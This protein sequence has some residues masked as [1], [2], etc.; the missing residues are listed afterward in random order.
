MTVT[1]SASASQE[2]QLTTTTK[3]KKK[4]DIEGVNSEAVAVFHTSAAVC[5]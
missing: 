1:H 2:I 3:K 5:V 4:K